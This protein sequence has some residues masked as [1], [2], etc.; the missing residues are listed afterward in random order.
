LEGEDH[1]QEEEGDSVRRVA[2]LLKK[3]KTEKKQR[4]EAKVQKEVKLAQ[5]ALVDQVAEPTE[6]R[7]FVEGTSIA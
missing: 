6:Q 2:K 7:F 5:Q 4:L 3:I 1:H